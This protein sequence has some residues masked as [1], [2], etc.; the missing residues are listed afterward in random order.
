MGKVK[1]TRPEPEYK[2]EE[3][4]NPYGKGKGAF[5]RL[6]VVRSSVSI[7]YGKGKEKNIKE[8]V[9]HLEKSINSLWER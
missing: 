4:T 3:V 7:P 5:R 9:L 6:L 2:D 8:R 1:S